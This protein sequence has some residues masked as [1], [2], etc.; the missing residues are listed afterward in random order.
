MAFAIPLIAAM[1]AGGGAAAAGGAIAAG[2]TLSA[3]ATGVS[4]ASGVLGLAQ[5]VQSSKF[6]Q[7]VLSQQAEIALENQ[8]RTVTEGALAA[9]RADEQAS[10]ELGSLIASQAASGLSGGS[11]SLQRKSMR[12]LAARDR[13]LITFQAEAQGAQFAQQAQDARVASRRSKT[14]SKYDAFGGILGIGGSLISGAAKYSA[15]RE[16]ELAL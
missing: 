12:E 11:H 14:K 2:S 1:G 4:I 10:A 5:T 7:A 8:E 6:E 3:I 16:K 9:Q 15:L 13:G